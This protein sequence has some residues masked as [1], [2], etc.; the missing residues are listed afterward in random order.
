[1]GKN[2]SEV[3]VF[4]T[5]GSLSLDAAARVAASLH[6]AEVRLYLVS[7]FPTDGV[8]VS[9]F[10]EVSV[11]SPPPH[12]L[13]EWSKPF[14]IA[15]WF[16]R[17]LRV[18]ELD[19]VPSV[20]AYFPHP[21]ELPGNYLAYSCP[22][23]HRRELL[24]DGLLNYTSGRFVPSRLLPRLRFETRILL[25]KLAA[26]WVGLNYVRLHGTHLTQYREIEYARS[27]TTQPLGFQTQGIVV[28]EVPDDDA[29]QVARQAKASSLLFL[30]Q[31]LSPLVS[32]GLE[33][34]L[35]SE[36]L[37]FLR[38]RAETRI[39][40]KAHPRGKNRS[41][42]LAKAGLE[43]TDLTGAL[44]A[45]RAIREHS[46]GHLFGFYSTPLLLMR[47]Q[48]A[49]CTSL[50]PRAGRRGVKN[51]DMVTEYEEAFRAAEVDVI[52]IG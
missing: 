4:V 3:H 25:R 5:Y 18:L 22:N 14:A 15:V 1:M 38:G 47:G 39:F 44:S 45:E 27:W 46:V 24:P 10:D 43:V 20:V 42:E 13:S 8:D 33:E 23:V 37:S 17:A 32:R 40:Y 30:D 6:A 31:E 52:V 49:E 51:P 28:T 41:G 48:V 7:L 35:R 50:L 11:M 12:R 29:P 2:L 9:V 26:Q 19:Q 21:F 16:S 36:A 34:R